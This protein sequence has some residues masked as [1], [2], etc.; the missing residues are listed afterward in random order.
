MTSSKKVWFHL[1]MDGLD[2]VYQEHGFTYQKERDKFYISAVESSL[3]FFENEGIT[4]TYFLIAKDLDNPEKRQAVQ[5][6]LSSG[7]NVACHGFRHR[8]LHDMTSVEKREEIVSA[9]K[10][11]RT[12]SASRVT[13]FVPL[14]IR[15]TS[16]LFSFFA[17]P[18]IHTIAQS[19]PTIPS[20]NA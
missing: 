14:A 8:Y 2:V 16:R 18:I 15:S 9:K 5:H 10:R 1:D 11:S 17:K 4:A 12:L 3:T 20:R 7:H 13:V 19:F 6:I